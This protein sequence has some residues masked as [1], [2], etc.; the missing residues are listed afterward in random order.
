MFLSLRPRVTESEKQKSSQTIESQEM[1]NVAQSS[2]KNGPNS[3]HSSS[4][5]PH[6]ALQSVRGDSGRREVS[7]LEQFSQLL[8][9][10]EERVNQ[11]LNE[12]STV[13][14][15]KLNELEKGERLAETIVAKISEKRRHE[16]EALREKAKTMKTNNPIKLLIGRLMSEVMEAAELGQPEKLI[17]TVTDLFHRAGGGSDVSAPAWDIELQSMASL[18][19]GTNE[20]V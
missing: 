12:Q 11:A 2:N 14:Q 9:N 6:S 16:V 5:S 18:V 13:F 4:R 17:G 3:A 20:N 7:V 1:G 15:S 10:M 19:S 8:K